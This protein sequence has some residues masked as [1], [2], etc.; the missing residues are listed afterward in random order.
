MVHPNFAYRKECSPYGVILLTNFFN[1]YAA[2]K[3]KIIMVATRR[4]NSRR[5]WPAIIWILGVLV[6]IN[7]YMINASHHY[8]LRG[9]L[10]LITCTQEYLTNDKRKLGVKMLHFSWVQIIENKFPQSIG[11]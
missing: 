11:W 6:G 9:Y 7:L 2:L 8:V 1:L 4:N 3:K 10:L 5:S